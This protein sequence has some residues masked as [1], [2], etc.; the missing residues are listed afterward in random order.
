MPSVCSLFWGI[1]LPPRISEIIGLA[2]NPPQNLERQWV[3]GQNLDNK[4]VRG[5]LA[6]SACIA[7]AFA[8]ICFLNFEVK[9]GRHIEL[10]KNQKTTLTGGK[11][12]ETS[13][14]TEPIFFVR[15]STF[16]HV[17]ETNHSHPSLPS[18]LQEG[19]RGCTGQNCRR[20]GS[21]SRHPFLP[22]PR[23]VTLCIATTCN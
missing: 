10:W 22:R 15:L 4:W 8:M 9:V 3:R 2:R 17:F 14:W 21:A 5:W 6:I 13:Q 12:R 18:V 23:A 7:S 11:N 1:P 16:S 20:E 19:R